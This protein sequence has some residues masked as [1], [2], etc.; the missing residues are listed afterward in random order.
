MPQSTAFRHDGGVK[1]WRRLARLVSAGLIIG[2]GI[3]NLS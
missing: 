1:G 2:L 3:A